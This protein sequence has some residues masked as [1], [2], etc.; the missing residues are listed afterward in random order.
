MEV[1]ENTKQKHIHPKGYFN[2]Y[3][4]KPKNIELRRQLLDKEIICECGCKILYG[5]QY[6]HYITNKHKKNME[7]IIEKNINI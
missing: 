5:S 1:N 6:K 4:N 2:K 7:K 3:N